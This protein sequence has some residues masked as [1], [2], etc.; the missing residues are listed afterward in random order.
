MDCKEIIGSIVLLP[1][2]EQ[3]ELLFKLNGHHST[4]WRR[5]RGITSSK[6]EGYEKQRLLKAQDTE[7]LVEHINRLTLQGL[8]PTKAIVRN[9]IGELSNIPPGKNYI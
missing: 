8:P 1:P 7:A 2:T 3:N 6:H 4:V 5:Q 9:F